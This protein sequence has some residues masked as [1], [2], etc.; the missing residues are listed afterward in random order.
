[1]TDLAYPVTLRPLSEEEGGGW[2]AEFPDLPGC[3]AD[4][5]TPE[6]AIRESEDAMKSWL[7]AM[8]EGDRPIPAPSRPDLAA[9]SGKWVLR[10]PKSLHK[11]L[12]DRARAEGVSLNTLAVSLL[13]LGLGERAGAG[14]PLE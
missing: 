5:E 9:Y 8:R 2:L 12:A 4:G 6:E 7:A 3:M 14:R 11:R 10:A 13:A 1:M